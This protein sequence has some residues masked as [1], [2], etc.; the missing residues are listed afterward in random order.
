MI[1]PCTITR[2]LTR[3]KLMPTRLNRL[4]LALDMYA[5]NQILQ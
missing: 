2:A 4:T 3:R 1:L 5:W